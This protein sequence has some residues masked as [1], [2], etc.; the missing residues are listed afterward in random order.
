MKV[1]HFHPTR[2]L[3]LAEN[4]YLQGRQTAELRYDAL[5]AFIQ[6]LADG[7]KEQA[8][9]DRKRKRQ[10]LFNQ[11]HVVVAALDSIVGEVEEMLRISGKH[12]H[13]EFAKEPKL[14]VND[15][16]KRPRQTLNKKF[17][18]RSGFKDTRP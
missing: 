4:A 9:A 1:D 16:L 12:L 8:E 3:S 15:R 17:L 18:T 10:Q 5:S 13:A 2:L 6:G 11:G 14:V 7:L